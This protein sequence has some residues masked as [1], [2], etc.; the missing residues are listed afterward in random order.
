MC[1]PAVCVEFA[2][3]NKPI[4]QAHH[5]YSAV[6]HLQKWLDVRSSNEVVHNFVW[7][8]NPLTHP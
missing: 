3:K 5:Q 2:I 4:N 1:V 7:F 8:L 6:F